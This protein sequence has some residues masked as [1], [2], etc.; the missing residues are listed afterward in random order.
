MVRW[1]LCENKVQGRSPIKSRDDTA[2][3]VTD[4]D[5]AMDSGILKSYRDRFQELMEAG[6]GKRLGL[7]TQK[8][9]PAQ[10]GPSKSMK[11]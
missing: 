7:I 9:K 11:G 6:G 8:Q 10:A 4:E 3:L 2:I 1:S 5:S